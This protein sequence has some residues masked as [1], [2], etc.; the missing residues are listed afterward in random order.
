MTSGKREREEARG[1]LRMDG[2]I[3]LITGAGT[4]IGRSCMEIF[5]REGAFVVGVGRRQGPLNEV[6]ATVT[7]AGGKAEVIAANLAEAGAC[8]SVA[9]VTI[10][11]HGRID[12]LVNCA[13]IGGRAYRTL[14]DGG[15]NA[16]ARNPNRALARADAQQPRL[17]LLHVQGTAVAAMR[18]S[19][20][21]GV[22]QHRQHIG[23]PRAPGR[24]RVRRRQGGHCEHDAADGGLLRPVQHPDQLCLTWVYGH[25]HD[26]RLAVRGDGGSRQPNGT[27]ATRWAARRSQA[28]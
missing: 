7:Y 26:G 5:A 24:A 15:M 27:T 28:R 13:A 20:G 4:G 16:I 8:Q 14:R 25:S 12:A 18:K 22:S 9:E 23:R 3:A 11:R 6:C 19:G 2:K 17:H 10:E 1:M 21:G